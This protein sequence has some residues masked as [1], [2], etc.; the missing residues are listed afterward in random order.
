MFR[1]PGSMVGTF[2]ATAIVLL[3]LD[4]MA[5]PWSKTL[6][7]SDKSIV[8]I[9]TRSGSVKVI[10]W[11]KKEIKIESDG[12][13]GPAVR[14]DGATVTI[15][16][17]A[18]EMAARGK[19][20]AAKAREIAAKAREIA[21]KARERA[22]QN[23]GTGIEVDV[24]VGELGADLGGLQWADDDL[25]VHVPRG[26]SVAVVSVSGEVGLSGVDGKARLKSVSGGVRLEGI[27][28]ELE[29]K[30]VS[31]DVVIENVHSAL[32]EAKTVSGSLRLSGMQSKRLRLKSHSGDIRFEGVLPAGGSLEAKTFSGDVEIRLARTSAFDLRARSRS[33]DV[34]IGFELKAGEKSEHEARGRA[35]GGGAELELSSF[36]GD[37]SVQPE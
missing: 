19:E 13:Q 11:E 7:A 15:G 27:R 21:E 22:A 14:I 5:D 20:M 29:A 18:S 31:G 30:A 16:T 10:G 17:S 25:T 35:G 28:G 9:E 24:D 34:E 12:E 4:A 23:P 26:A 37:L 8:V 3:A 6:A 1:E 33:G 36:S 2:L 32:L